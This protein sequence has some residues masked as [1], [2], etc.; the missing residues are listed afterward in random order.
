LNAELFPVSGPQ[1]PAKNDEN[2]MTW[3]ARHRLRTLVFP[4]IFPSKREIRGRA[5]LDEPFVNVPAAVLAQHRI[6]RTFTVCRHPD[7]DRTAVGIRLQMCQ[8]GRHNTRFRRS[9]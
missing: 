4:A 7:R 9:V 5:S 2:A 3:G 8:T 1:L 6:G